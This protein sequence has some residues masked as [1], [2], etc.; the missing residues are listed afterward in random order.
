M[1]S[2]AVFFVLGGAT[3][4]AAT[5]IGSNQLKANSVVTGK[6]KKEAVTTSKIKKD[7]VTGAKVKESSLGQVPSALNA[8]NAG[9]ANTVNGQT[10]HKIFKTLNAGESGV[11]VASIAGFTITATCESSNVDV[12]LTTP[13]SPASVASV[14][15]NG[16]PE[17]AI[18]D[19][20]SEVSGTPSTIRLDDDSPEDN[21]YGESTFSAALNN[22]VVISGDVGYDYDTFGNNP[23]N[24]CIVF[25]E[26]AT[27]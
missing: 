4:F 22:G 12:T 1:S 27:G 3:A 17:G 26:V 25:G 21:D 7:A 5:K 6:I 10:V 2:I 24:V 8:T 14:E 16:S 23:A 19:Y 9:N 11:V 13:S 20:D 15:G 18:F